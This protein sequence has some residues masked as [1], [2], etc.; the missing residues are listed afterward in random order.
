MPVRD[1]LILALDLNEKKRALEIVDKFSD[2]INTFKVG[3]ELFVSAGP[4][5]VDEINRK[6]KKVFLD[7]KFHDISNTASRAA[8]AAARL[9][10]YMFNV[11]ANGGLEMMKKCRESVTELCIRENIERPKMLGVTVLTGLTPDALKNELSVTHSIRTHVNHLSRLAID[12]GL[13]GVVASG[14]ETAMIR[15]HFGKNFII[16]TPGIR[17]SWSPPDDQRRTATPREAIKEGADYI[18]L[19][20]AVLNQ[21]DPLKAL[22]LISAEILTA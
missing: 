3:L 11:H 2:Y 22:E 1:K 7:L 15:T 12:A 13:D 6:G 14:H 20:R 4:S 10:V 18:V 17:T 9:G 5:I 8:M 16:V 21:P 19:G